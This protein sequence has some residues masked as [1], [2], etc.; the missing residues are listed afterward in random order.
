MNETKHTPGP[1]EWSGD[2]LY[3]PDY[4]EVIGD[5]FFAGEQSLSCSNADRRL[6][7]AAPDL[8][9]ALQYVND[10][11]DAPFDHAAKRAIP[12]KARAALAKAT[13]A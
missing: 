6:I 8:L 13:G 9:Q 12:E 4:Q 7:A 2:Y 10:Y 1:W 3:G 5:C 11:W